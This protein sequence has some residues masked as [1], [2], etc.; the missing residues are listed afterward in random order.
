MNDDTIHSTNG[1][2]NKDKDKRIYI[3]KKEED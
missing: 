2:S 3:E 1:D